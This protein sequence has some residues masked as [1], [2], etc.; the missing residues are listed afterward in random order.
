MTEINLLPWREAKREQEKK[1]FLTL[2]LGAALL[3]VGIVMLVNYYVNDLVSLQTARNQ[4]LQDEINIFNKQ[5]IEIKQLKTIRTSL[6]SRMKIV[7]GLQARRTL[8]VHLFDEL[9]KITP[10]GIYLTQ[11]KREGDKVTVQGYSESNT[12]VS[13]LMRNIE[14]SFWIQEPLLTEIK[15]NKEAETVVNQEFILSFILKPKST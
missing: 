4:K 12:N 2:L 11:V 8:T 13:I 9:I 14:K 5:I 15:K 3:G 10:D 1:D 7:Q 6:I